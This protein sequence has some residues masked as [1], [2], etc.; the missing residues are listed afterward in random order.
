MR[1][2][3]PSE[4]ALIRRDFKEMLRSKEAVDVSITY[5]TADSPADDLVYGGVTSSTWTSHTINV[6]AIQKF[7]SIRDVEILKFGIL[8]VGDCLFHFSRGV[9]LTVV[10]SDNAVLTANGVDWIPVSRIMSQPAI[11]S[12]W[13]VGNH[14][15]AQ[16]IPA[17]LKQ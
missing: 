7:I 3:S 17:R 1:P 11:Y 16:V 6:K 5:K 4:I 15:I 13:S 14:Q 10:T 12:T 9:D 8:E 2:I